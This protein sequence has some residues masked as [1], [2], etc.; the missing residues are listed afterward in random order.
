MR[1]W[2][3]PAFPVRQPIPEF[4]TCSGTARPCPERIEAVV[5]DRLP[6]DLMSIRIARYLSGLI[7]I[8]RNR[9]SNPPGT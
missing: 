6:R 1:C 9:T 5:P 7:L 8:L 3:L 2:M 4:R